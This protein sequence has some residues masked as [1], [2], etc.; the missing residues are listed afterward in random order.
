MLG[1]RGR[2][3]IYIARLQCSIVGQAAYTHR[4]W[5]SLGRV[6]P[7][8]RRSVGV[9]YLLGKAFRKAPVLMRAAVSSHINA[10]AST[11]EQVANKIMPGAWC[12]PPSM[13]EVTG[14]ALTIG[15]GV[16]LGVGE[17]VAA[18]AVA[19]VTVTESS[20]VTNWASAAASSVDAKPFE[21]VSSMAVC[22][23]V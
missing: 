18:H 22:T 12:E 23:S 3:R 15:L 8:L 20:V 17:G 5:H 6:R 1:R 2:H 16:G 14:L 9:S 11:A 10:I 7:L 4:A 21:L 19:V 13:T